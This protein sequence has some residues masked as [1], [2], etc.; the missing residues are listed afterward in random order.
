MAPSVSLSII[1][2]IYNTQAYLEKCV[3]SLVNQSVSDFEILLI[4]DGSTDQSKQLAEKLQQQF[5][6]LI[7]LYTKENGGLSDARNFGLAKAKGEFVAFVDSDDMVDITMFEKMLNKAKSTNAEI[8]FCDF[9]VLNKHGE[10]VMVWSAGEFEESGIVLAESPEM[11]GNILPSACNKTY[12]RSLFE[13]PD[14]L[15]DKGIW[16]EDFAL[17]PYLMAS[18]Q[19]VAKVSEPLYKYMK[20]DDSITN[21]YSSKVLDGLTSFA[22]LN[23]RFKQNN[24]SEKYASSLLSMHLTMLSATTV[25]IFKS[26][27]FIQISRDMKQVKKVIQ[28]FGLDWSNSQEF[29]QL[30]FIQRWVL[31]S[32]KYGLALPMALVYKV[33]IKIHDREL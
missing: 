4:D 13:T 28:T 23:N 10:R 15:F 24:L 9:D 26:P 31:L 21:S 1:V 3:E 29:K 19:R 11:L 8:V 6:G 32:I 33:K 22:L 5:S 16:Y 2:P 17:I 20:R 30:G 12:K 7:Q 27:S 18:C 14:N 25:R